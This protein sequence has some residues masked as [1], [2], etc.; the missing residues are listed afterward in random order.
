MENKKIDA[1][2]M[3]RK[4]REKLSRIYAKDPEKEKRDL[5][6]VRKKYGMKDKMI[7]EHFR[8]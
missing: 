1:V 8:K 4:I 5:E 3:M 6:I 2:K 7:S